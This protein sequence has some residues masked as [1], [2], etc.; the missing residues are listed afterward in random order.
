MP[1]YGHISKIILQNDNILRADK[2]LNINGIY[3]IRFMAL[4]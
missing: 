3:K 4:T 1:S 2:L